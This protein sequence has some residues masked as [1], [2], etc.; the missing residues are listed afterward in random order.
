MTKTIRQQIDDLKLSI[1]GNKFD[2]WDNAREK[3][4]NARMDAIIDAVDD[5]NRQLQD[6][7]K[8]RKKS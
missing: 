7:D 2:T 6:L 4:I 5:L 8:K 1:F 3:F